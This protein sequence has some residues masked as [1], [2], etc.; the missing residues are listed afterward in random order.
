MGNKGHRV[1]DWIEC[2][3]HIV[4]FKS[5]HAHDIEGSVDG[6]DFESTEGLILSCR[7]V[8]HVVITINFDEIPLNTEVKGREVSVAC[9]LS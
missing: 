5:R 2:M 7:D 6:L 9:E 8:N 4:A 1:S 3:C